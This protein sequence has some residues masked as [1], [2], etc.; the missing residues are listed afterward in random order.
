MKA[1]FRT[2]LLATASLC[3]AASTQAG[4]D[5]AGAARLGGELTPFGA[6]RAGN[7]AGTI[8]EWTGGHMTLPA[9][10]ESGD[11]RPDPFADEQPLFT[12]TAD[13]MGEHADR[14]SEGVKA[15]F[16]NYPDSFAIDV[17]PSHRT[18]AAPQW[19]YDHTRRNAESAALTEGGLSL[20]GAY[21]GP[22]FPIPENGAEA[23]W[24]HLLIWS[25]H[26]FYTELANYVGT[27]DGDRILSSAGDMWN[28]F[29]YYDPHGS[30]EGFEGWYRYNLSRISDPP[31]I[32][33]ENIVVNEHT[34]AKDIGRQAWQYLPGQRRVRKAP[35]LNYD[36]PY[37][38]SNGV[39]NWD[40]VWVFNG[41]IDRYDWK[42]VGKK[43]MYIPYNVNGM[44]ALPV[45]EAFAEHH[46]APE[47]VRFELHRVWEVEATLADG[48]R[49][50]VAKRRFYLDEDSW[51]AVLG[52]GYDAAG[53]LWRV[54]FSLPTLM[55]D[56]PAVVAAPYGA[57]NVQTGEWY[58]QQVM[59]G[60]DTRFELVEPKS[61]RFFTPGNLSIIS[62]R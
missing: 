15:L 40:E 58:A 24:N 9:G 50:V 33:G 46:W 4:A 3:V 45:E 35:Q 5:E 1:W 30:R 37:S 41:A 36:T 56:I 49:N 42:L 60:L 20:T 34:D 7:A 21:G 19:V 2:T 55:P 11:P 12:I 28:Q 39:I 31:L 27:R 29:P 62:Q 52:E 53:E 13:N 57:I 17:Y 54:Y 18:A 14:L 48:E 61:D 10:Y 43:E 51:M 26:V 59:N 32:A 16:R 25:G 47:A 8:P 22:P 23:I 44:H 6:E 38:Q